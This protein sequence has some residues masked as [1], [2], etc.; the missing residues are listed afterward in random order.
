[1]FGLADS[2]EASEGAD[3]LGRGQGHLPD[4]VQRCPL[5]ERLER[6]T[7]GTQRTSCAPSSPVA[8]AVAP[9]TPLAAPSQRSQRG[10][11]T[12]TRSPTESSRSA[13]RCLVREPTRCAVLLVAEGGPGPRLCLTS[14]TLLGREASGR[15]TAKVPVASPACLL[16]L[17][18]SCCQR[19]LE[20]SKVF[21]YSS[22]LKS[23]SFSDAQCFL[24]YDMQ[25]LSVG[26]HCPPPT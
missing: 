8:A 15:S 4:T 11:H 6:Q 1:M 16:G 17:A 2:C 18:A 22:S 14:V 13:T 21:H 24:T 7:V 23:K 5:A 25:T 10:S 12:P 3:R 26:R 19:P 9:L 20:P